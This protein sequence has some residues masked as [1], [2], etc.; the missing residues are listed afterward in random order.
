MQH[1]C[2]SIDNVAVKM[3]ADGSMTFEGYASM[4]GG[5][6]SYGDSIV[7]GA[8]EKTLQNRERPVRLRWNHY[9]P[10][11]GKLPE[12]REDD[13]GLY[14]KGELTPGHSLANDV[15]ASLKHGAVDGMSIGYIVIDSEQMGGIEYLKEIELIEI[16]IVEEPADLGAKVSNV[17]D[18]QKRID[19]LESLKECE[20]FLREAG[21]AKATSLALVSKIKSL[22]R[23]ESVG[24]QKTTSDAKSA[25]LLRLIDSMEF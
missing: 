24:T 15:Y 10:V 1:K 8:Y 22:G 6:D 14:V 5:V 25:D 18:A 19:G 21:M 7:K 20:R 17:K 16:S 23:S 13:Y 12:L 3:S 9:G 4:F 11:I 2:L